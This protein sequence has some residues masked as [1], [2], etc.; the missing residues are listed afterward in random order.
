[1]T[2]INVEPFNSFENQ[3]PLVQ[4]RY[5]VA[6]P[7]QVLHDTTSTWESKSVELLSGCYA[8]M[9]NSAEFFSETIL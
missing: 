4:F 3:P 1:M 8:R 6:T 5:L 9:G 7:Y 2:E